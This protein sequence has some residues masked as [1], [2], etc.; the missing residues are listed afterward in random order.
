MKE[1]LVLI[2]INILV[3]MT[4]PASVVAQGKKDFGINQKIRILGISFIHFFPEN[5]KLTP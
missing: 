1:R 4:L 2:L 3:I 5:R